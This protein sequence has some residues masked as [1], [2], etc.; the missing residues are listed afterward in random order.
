MILGMWLIFINC[1]STRME[2][3]LVTANGKSHRYG[4]RVCV[5][6]ATMLLAHQLLLFIFLTGWQRWGFSRGGALEKWLF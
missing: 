2:V 4:V 5:C 6:V 1:V 3:S